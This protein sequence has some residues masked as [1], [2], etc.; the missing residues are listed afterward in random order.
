MV[1]LSHICKYHQISTNIY[2]I[3]GIPSDFSATALRHPRPFRDACRDQR[4]MSSPNV[5]SAVALRSAG[6]VLICW[7]F[8]TILGARRRDGETAVQRCHVG[9]MLV[10]C[11]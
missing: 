6:A 8:G 10:S 4:D 1:Q 2:V 5:R 3:L 11:W 9:V 7:V